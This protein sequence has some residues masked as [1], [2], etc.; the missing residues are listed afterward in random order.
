MA[1][2]DAEEI[3]IVSIHYP[4][5]E[6]YLKQRGISVEQYAEEQAN[7]YKRR[8]PEWYKS[9]IANRDAKVSA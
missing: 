9:W 2:R 6:E 5:L 7:Y 3:I 8:I 1:L 4:T